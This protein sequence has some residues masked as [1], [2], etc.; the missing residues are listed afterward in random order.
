[1]TKINQIIY[2]YQQTHTHTHFHCLLQKSLNE[3]FLFKIIHNITTSFFLSSIKC[4]YLD[5]SP[6]FF[7]IFYIA[8]ITTKVIITFKS[9]LF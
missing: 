8:I 2:A 5:S 9:K 3:D 4:V 1:M 6:L 7:E